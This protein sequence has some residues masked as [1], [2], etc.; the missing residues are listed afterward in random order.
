MDTCPHR[1][2]LRWSLG[3]ALG[4]LL[5]LA[6]LELAALLPWLLHPTA[7]LMAPPSRTLLL[8]LAVCMPLGLAASLWISRAITDPLASLAQTAQRIARGDLAVRAEPGRAT[9]GLAVMLHHFNDMAGALEALERDRKAMTAAVSHE[10]RTPLTVLCARLHAACDGVVATD[11]AELRRL[12]DQAEHLGRLVGDLHTLTL[13]Q[14]GRLTL[15]R[16]PLDMA[17][18]ARESLQHHAVRLRQH[19]IDA[20]LEGGDIPMPLQG[21]PDRLRQVLCNLIENATR[22]GSAGG[23][24]VLRLAH[25]GGRV[26]LAVSDSGGGDPDAVRRHMLRGLGNPAHP[27]APAAGGSGLGL[28]IVLMLVRQHGGEVEVEPALHNGRRVG[29]TVLLSLPQAPAPD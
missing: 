18:L 28:A 26:N 12:L 13:A 6:A 10:L 27:R 3:I 21:D 16:A 22:H 20:R 1:A 19:G 24:L 2:G 25:K 5:T 15:R 29:V 23:Q 7:G 8:A 11:M 14:A 4:G 9:G 17:T